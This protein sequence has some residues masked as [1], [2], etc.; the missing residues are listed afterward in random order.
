MALFS[1]R[2]KYWRAQVRT[3]G[4][5]GKSRTPR[6]FDAKAEAQVWARSIENAIYRGIFI[7]NSEALRTTLLKAIKRYEKETIARKGYPEQE[8]QRTKYW[9]TQP[10]AKRFLATLRGVDFAKYRDMRIDSGRAAATVRQE[11]QAVSHL[12]ETARK[13]WCMEGLLNPL[14]NIR[15][16]SASNERDRRLE[17]GQFEQISAELAR[18][19]NPPPAAVASVP[20]AAAPC[21][22][23]AAVPHSRRVD[24]F[25]DL[26]KTSP[27]QRQG[28]KRF[29]PVAHEW[30][31]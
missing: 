7:D 30:L 2:G 26:P 20:G 8:L 15:K 12:F 28:F 6:T 18:R 17:A 5:E 4:Q 25:A 14:K 22:Q 10:L 1:K 24:L 9:K 31:A 19:G 29:R 16:P 13:D 23:R 11:L 21:R 3:K 27:A